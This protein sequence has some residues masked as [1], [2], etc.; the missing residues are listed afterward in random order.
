MTPTP[1]AFLPTSPAKGGQGAR[2]LQMLSFPS[3][4]L[5]SLRSEQERQHR[6]PTQFRRR[7][8]PGVGRIYAGP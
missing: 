4:E 7:P 1:S 3:L 8:R 2:P 6:K 5:Y